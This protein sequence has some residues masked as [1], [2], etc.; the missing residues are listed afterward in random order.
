MHKAIGNSSRPLVRAKLEEAHNPI[1]TLN[2]AR[3]VKEFEIEE[4]NMDI[5][6]PT[7][8]PQ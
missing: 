4:F 1:I 2:I 7:E 5:T 8:Q 3:H 6:A